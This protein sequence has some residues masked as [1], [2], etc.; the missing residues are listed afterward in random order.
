MEL[1][2]SKERQIRIFPGEIRASDQVD[3]AFRVTGTLQELPVVRGQ[4][5]NAG[6]LVATLDRRDFESTLSR[7]KSE[8][9]SAEAQLAAM[10]K[11][12]RREDISSFTAQVDAAR[13]KYNE[14]KISL[15]RYSALLKAGAVSRAD[16][17]RVQAL[18]DVARQELKVA[19]Q[20]L[21]KGKAGSRSEEI[22]MQEARIRGLASQVKSAQDALDD[23]ELR[24]PFDGT[25]AEKYVENFQAVQKDQSIIALQNISALEVVASIP[26]R[27]LLNLSPAQNR[28][29]ESSSDVYTAQARF[30]SLP[31]RLFDLRF[32][33]V[34]TKGNIQAQTYDVTLTMQKPDDLLILPG[35]GVDVLI[36]VRNGSA[37]TDFPVPVSALGAG[38]GNTHFVWKVSGPEDRMTVSKADVK[39]TGYLGDQCLISGD[40]AEGDRIVTVGVSYL[41]DEDSILPYDVTGGRQQ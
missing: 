34:A 37:R 17:D 13:A 6:D 28:S 8:L 14:A 12:A 26:G 20:N 36:S 1:R 22:D 38:Q 9:Q 40:V 21:A 23:T 33:E 31:D 7:T 5:L 41:Q 30:S 24:A 16:Y 35:M 32:K 11:G 19:E 27:L 4:L 18:H 39:I 25:V 15:D 3:L 2:H 29:A 10:K